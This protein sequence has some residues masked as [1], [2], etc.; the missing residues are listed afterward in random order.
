MGPALWPGD[1]DI[2]AQVNQDNQLLGSHLD[3]LHE[4]PNCMGIAH[5]R[6]NAYWV[7]DGYHG[8][9][10]YYDFQEPHGYGE[11]DHSDGIVR[12]YEEV[13]L[14]RVPNVPGHLVLDDDSG[15]LYVANTGAGEVLAVDTETGDVSSPAPG[16][17]EPLQEYSLME[18]IEFSVLA[19]GF[20]R[21]SGLAL[22]GELLFVSENGSGD[23]VAIDLADG[24][25]AGRITVPEGNGI[26][27]L[28]VGPD[29][30]LYYAHKSGVVARVDP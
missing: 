20:D 16:A 10:V 18:G 23:I 9:L 21:P 7:F 3:M 12:R 27:G 26:M 6:R 11:D 25:E 4:S 22:D 13:E 17:M 8:N 29:G 28:E 14:E 19:E 5:D 2:F 24:A 30:S 15:I 1:L